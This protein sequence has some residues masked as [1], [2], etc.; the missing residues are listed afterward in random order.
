MAV[1][2]RKAPPRWR[3]RA[4]RLAIGAVLA[5]PV[6]LLAW[7]TAL[8]HEKWFVA[9]GLHPLT[10]AGAAL[11]KPLTWLTLADPVLLWFSAAAFWRFRR[12]RSFIPEP[13][14]LGGNPEAREA[15]YA[16]I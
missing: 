2:S 11:G 14:E 3:A 10:M 1:R 13:G 8:A 15:L 9:A 7:G 12:H 6:S 5:V 16:F 4:R